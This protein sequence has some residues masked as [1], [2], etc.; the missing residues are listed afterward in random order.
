MKKVRSNTEFTTKIT[1]LEKHIP[2]M[3]MSG[4]L[5]TGFG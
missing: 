4:L 1:L 2:S 3:D 5:Y